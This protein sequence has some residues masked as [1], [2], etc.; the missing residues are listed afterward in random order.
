MTV[1]ATTLAFLVTGALIITV[2]API[3]LLA[4]FIHDRSKGQLW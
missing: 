2:A 1:S 4:L 3:I